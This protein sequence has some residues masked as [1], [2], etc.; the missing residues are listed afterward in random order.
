MALQTTFAQ[1]LANF[2]AAAMTGNEAFGFDQAGTTVGATAKTLRDYFLSSGQFVDARDFSGIDS[3]GNTDS[4]VAINTALSQAI[5]ANLPLKFPPGFFSVVSVPIGYGMPQGAVMAILG[6]GGFGPQTN[7]NY[8]LPTPPYALAINTCSTIFV[9]QTKVLPTFCLNTVSGTILKDFGIMGQNYYAYSNV[10][11]NCPLDNY[12]AYLGAGIRGG[13]SITNS[14]YCAIAIDPL[15]NATPADGGY[16]GLTYA[17]SFGSNGIILEK[18]IMNYFFVCIALSTSGAVAENGSA[19]TLQNVTG[20]WC[21][22]FAATGQSQSRL[23]T[24]TDGGFGGCRQGFDGINYGNSQGCP[25]A[26]IKKINVGYAYR[27]FAVQNAFGSTTME[28]CYAESFRQIGLFG[29]GPSSG[30]SGLSIKGGDLNITQQA[31][32]PPPP[33]IILESYAATKMSGGT[34]GYASNA[35]TIPALNLIGG[36]APIDLDCMGI[37]VVSP[38]QLGLPMIGY[39]KNM[40]SQ[41]SLR[42]CIANGKLLTD[43]YPRTYGLDSAATN[44]RLLVGW[45]SRFVPNANLGEYAFLPGTSLPEIQLNASSITLNINA[46]PVASSLTFN[47]TDHQSIVVGDIFY[48]QAIANTYSLEQYVVPMLQ[49][50]SVVGSLV[51]CALL[52]DPLCY[53]TVANWNIYQAGAMFVAPVQWAP[54]QTVTATTNGTNTITLTG[55]AGQYN[56]LQ[57]GDW[58]L[59]SSGFLPSKAR[60]QS[61]VGTSMVT[62]NAPAVGSG[63]TNLYFGRLYPLTLGTPI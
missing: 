22:T 63:A 58:L 53:D 16:P 39:N 12:A 62:L 31:G 18:I 38:G 3:T 49:V 32:W 57:V 25:P 40:T 44:H 37:G 14:P 52:F 4:S 50:T 56:I 15:I 45:G 26:L 29:R 34:L 5:S 47:S 54:T 23:F 1:L 27:L 33:P 55:G 2:P 9:N 36:V 28:E 13:P 43:I 20:S 11:Y 30:G 51:T 60:V 19:I 46:W 21:D 48:W 61:G 7:S 41:V 59:D 6:A 42:D 17:N 10:G 35:A 8:D 24:M